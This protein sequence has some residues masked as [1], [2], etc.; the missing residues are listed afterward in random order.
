MPVLVAQHS[1][2]DVIRHL[3][4]QLGEGSDPGDGTTPP[5][6]PWP[7]YKGVSPSSP[8]QILVVTD[9]QGQ[10]DGVS[11][12][13]GELYQHY[14]FQVKVRDT[15][16]PSTKAEQIR[17]AFAGRTRLVTVTIGSA[18]Y[19]VWKV[20]KVGQVLYL[21]KPPGTKRS[22]FTVNAMAVIDPL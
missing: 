21:G 10:V 15:S 18:R 8:D 20:A 16:E 3:L 12:L 13:D 4:I 19:L 9:T 14:G 11:M 2:A 1:P 6:Q 5:T 7:V 17:Q 22:Q